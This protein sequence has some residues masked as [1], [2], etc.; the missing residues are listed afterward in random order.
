M[1]FHLYLLVVA[2]FFPLSSYAT[3]STFSANNEGWIIID[4]VSSTNPLPSSG[5]QLI[6]N[7][8]QVSGGRLVVQDIA[9]NWNWI[10]APAKFRQS[11]ASFTDLKIDLI[12]DDSSSLF[13]IRFFIADGVSSAWYE[14]PLSGTPGNSVLNLSAP[15]QKSQWNVTGNREQLIANVNAFYIR[16]DLNNN[17]AS[18]ADFVDRVAL[19]NGTEPPV[20]TFPVSFPTVQDS[21]Y[22]I[23]SSVNLED[24]KNVGIPVP[25][26]GSQITIE[27]PL[28]DAPRLVLPGAKARNPLMRT[29]RGWTTAGAALSAKLSATL[30]RYPVSTLPPAPAVPALERSAES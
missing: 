2:L 16:I 20:P 28:T 25:G 8:P 7:D 24:W 26:N 5:I 22:Q 9:N 6:K 19:V 27:I 23:E 17:V 10:V 13:N 18:E 21:D 30:T 11:W 14:F 3:E 29:R 4:H 12:T 15:L 1:K